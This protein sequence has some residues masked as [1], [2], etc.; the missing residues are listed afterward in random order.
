MPKAGS[1]HNHSKA[2]ANPEFL[3]DQI[4]K[5][6][7]LWFEGDLG[8]IR[9]FK[10]SKAAPGPEWRNFQNATKAMTEEETR[11]RI[12]PQLRIAA[13]GPHRTTEECW[14]EFNDIG[15][16]TSGLVAFLPVFEEYWKFVISEFASDG[17]SYIEIRGNFNKV[18]LAHFCQKQVKK[19]LFKNRR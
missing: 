2:I 16:L 14:K 11:I 1:L 10:F 5:N 18:F 9:N 7:C 6:S 19:S 12:L 17:Y 15:R 8:N 13:Q 4:L 3:M